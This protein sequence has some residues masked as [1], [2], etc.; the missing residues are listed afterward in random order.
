[1]IAWA[2]CNTLMGVVH[3]FGGL[4]ATRVILGLT[5]GGLFPVSHRLIVY[6]YSVSPWN[7]SESVPF[8]SIAFLR[9]Q[10]TGCGIL[11]YLVVQT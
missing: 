10:V 6:V 1:M 7:L 2:V 8:A 11:S 3:N 5:E 4:I 9:L